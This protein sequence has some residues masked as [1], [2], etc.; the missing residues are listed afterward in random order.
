MRAHSQLV[1]ERFGSVYPNDPFQAQYHAAMLVAWQ[2]QEKA[3]QMDREMREMI[4]GALQSE[5]DFDAQRSACQEVSDVRSMFFD[6]ELALDAITGGNADLALKLVERHVLGSGWGYRGGTDLPRRVMKS[7]EKELRRL[8]RKLEQRW[9]A[10][11]HASLAASAQ[12]TGKNE[13]PAKGGA[14]DVAAGS[15]GGSGQ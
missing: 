1:E 2:W 11:S 14:D 3:V 9:L 4:E 15:G 7:V 10:S 13:T 12:T 6:A 5:N 8:E